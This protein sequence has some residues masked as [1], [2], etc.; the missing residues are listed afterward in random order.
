MTKILISIIWFLVFTKLL[1]F[2]LWLWQLKNYHW[3]RLKAHFETQRIR[4]IA[5]SLHGARFPEL[6]QKVL[7]I[8]AFGI[9][10]EFLILL[11]IYSLPGYL[12]YIFFLISIIL[13]PVIISILILLFQIPANIVIKRVL[14]RAEQRR[15]K[16]QSKNSYMKYFVKSLMY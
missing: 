16:Q 2:W 8:L 11:C 1:V 12:S 13:A 5:F 14:K 15:K 7:L 10:V 3:K 6:T 4:K 9:L